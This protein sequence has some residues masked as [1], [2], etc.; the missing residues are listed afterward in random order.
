M[1]KFAPTAAAIAALASAPLLW[2][3][4]ASAI[5]IAAGSELSID[6]SDSFTMAPPQ[7]ITFVNPASVGGTT[8]SFFGVVPIVFSH[9]GMAAAHV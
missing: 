3:S 6:G 1:R 9:A 2:A 5:P 8:G 7:V 4:P